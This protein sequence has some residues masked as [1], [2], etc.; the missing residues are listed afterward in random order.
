MKKVV[1][2]NCAKFIGKHQCQSLFFNKVTGLQLYLKKRLW[3][4]I[5]SV[6]FAHFLR[7]PFLQNTSR[8]LLLEMDWKNFE[9]D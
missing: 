6:S 1:L 4:R 8:R 5:F 2:R 7:I 9:K 3:H